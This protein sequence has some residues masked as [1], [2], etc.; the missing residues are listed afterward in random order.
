MPDVSATAAARF[1]RVPAQARVRSFPC[2]RI[3]LSMFF[4]L[5]VGPSDGNRAFPP[6]CEESVGSPHA[7]SEFAAPPQGDGALSPMEPR[8]DCFFSKRMK[9]SSSFIFLPVISL[10]ATLFLFPVAAGSSANDAVEWLFPLR[11]FRLR[12][13]VASLCSQEEILL[14]FAGLF[15]SFQRAIPAKSYVAPP[16][17]LP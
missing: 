10:S 11:R 17:P 12:K 4:S 6:H 14:D 8:K 1:M 15:L 7:E 2:L 13:P 3:F 9:R 16:P 5:P